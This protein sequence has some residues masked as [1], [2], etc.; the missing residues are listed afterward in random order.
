[1]RAF[2]PISG[3]YAVTLIALACSPQAVAKGVRL[4]DVVRLTPIS[5]KPGWPAPAVVE[6]TLPAFCSVGHGDAGLPRGAV[7]GLI[8]GR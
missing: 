5:L 1:M 2:G 3:V 8:D 7:L 6:P 4:L